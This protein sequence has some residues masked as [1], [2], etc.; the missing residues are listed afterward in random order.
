MLPGYTA[1]DITVTWNK[2]AFGIGTGLNYDMFVTYYG[3]TTDEVVA[4]PDNSAL[5]C[6]STTG[7]PPIH[8]SEPAGVWFGSVL[9]AT[10]ML[11]RPDGTKY[12]STP[13]QPADQHHGSIQQQHHH[14]TRSFRG[15]SA[16]RRGQGIYIGS[17]PSGWVGTVSS[18]NGRKVYFCYDDNNNTTDITGIADNA[19]PGGIKEVAYTYGSGG[20]LQP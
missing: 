14:H 13:R 4:M 10:N 11:T 18:S 5:A 17:V 6:T 3:Q 9:D 7:G 2:R 16:C 1:E 12:S 8:A 19:S 15:D 20:A